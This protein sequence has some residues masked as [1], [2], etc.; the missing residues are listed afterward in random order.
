MGYII[1]MARIPDIVPSYFIEEPSNLIIR[2]SIQHLLGQTMV[3]SS[4]KS[5]NWKFKDTLKDF[6]NFKNKQKSV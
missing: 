5:D 4:S 1:F 3:H 2:L 6:D